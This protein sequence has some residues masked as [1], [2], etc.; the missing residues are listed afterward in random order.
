MAV[1]AEA[2]AVAVGAAALAAAAAAAVVERTSCCCGGGGVWR[3]DHVPPYDRGGAGT[4]LE[5]M[6]GVPLLG[7]CLSA[8]QVL[9]RSVRPLT[10][11]MHGGFLRAAVLHP[12]AQAITQD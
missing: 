3:R 11:R 2:V 1:L 5:G 8:R 4:R 9:R 10:L 6:R 12:F 7:A